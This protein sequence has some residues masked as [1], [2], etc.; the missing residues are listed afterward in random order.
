MQA[1]QTML[2][3]RSVRLFIQ[4]DRPEDGLI[5]YRA[6]VTV[7][8]EGPAPRN[9]PMQE[10]AVC[11]LKL[12]IQV[13]IPGTLLGASATSALANVLG[14]IREQLN[15]LRRNLETSMGL[16]Q[17]LLKEATASTAQ[18][19]TTA[20]GL[21]TPGLAI[22]TLVNI[23]VN[24][25][26]RPVVG[27]GVQMLNPAKHSLEIW[28]P[29]Q[30]A[31]AAGEAAL[32]ARNVS[33]ALAQLAVGQASFAK[34]SEQLT[35][36]RDGTELAARRAELLIKVTAAVAALAAVVAYTGAAA[37]AGAGATTAAA[38]SAQPQV[39]VAAELFKDGMTRIVLAESPEAFDAGVEL[40]VED[41][42]KAALRAV[43]PRR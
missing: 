13:A 30:A 14:R 31:L 9:F 8:T 15:Q 11:V 21:L 22:P 26:M 35:A 7:D 10:L 19:V 24:P 41:A 1:L 5:V 43:M 20:L 42:P 27:A 38:G 3:L 25:A 4:W 39:R 40:C 34:A 23:A 18:K 12:G 36:F 32:Q 2:S 17:L 16:H 29:T 33:K 6:K 28:K 37:T